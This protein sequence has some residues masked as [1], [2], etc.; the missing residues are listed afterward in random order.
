M[1]KLV[2]F[3]FSLCALPVAALAQKEYLE[4]PAD[5]I[6]I[7]IDRLIA[8]APDSLKADVAGKAFNIYSDS[9]IMGHDAVAVHIADNYFLNGLLKWSD[10]ETYPLLYTYASFNRSSL[11]GMDSPDFLM[12]NLAGGMNSLRDDAG[13]FKLLFFYDPQCA[14]CHRYASAIAEMSRNYNGG[15]LSVFAVN[16]GS[17]REDWKRYV[18]ENFSDITTWKVDFYNLWDPEDANDYHR[19]FGVLSTPALLLLDSQNRI[20][21]RQL[22]VDAAKTLLGFNNAGGKEI[23]KL[24]NDMFNALAPVDTDAIAQISKSLAAKA[25]AD[26]TMY[27]EFFYELFNYLRDSPLHAYQEG[28]ARMASRYI[29]GRPE[30]WSPEYLAKVNRAIAAYN[31]N[32]LGSKAPSLIL[33][34]SCGV[35]VDILKRRSSKYTLL[36]FHI[37][38]CSDCRREFKV[39]D[40]NESKLKIKK[41]RVVCIYAGKDSDL[42]KGFIGRHPAG[43]EYYS[44][45]N[46]TSRMGEKYDIEFVPKLYLLDR[47]GRIVAKDIDAPALMQ[48]LQ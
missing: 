17:D 7:K 5:S 6:I 40:A 42:W 35:S 44:D 43:W 13:H 28:A 41:V 12:E 36:V 39:L 2:L 1:K 22:D 32:P 15:R 20:I 8:G 9:P 47:K 27:R 30:Y 33:K 23:R 24:F 46:R 25:S 37:V 34:D 16:T 4:E 10:P 19:K 3:F 29:L 18:A 21:G 11:I 45:I 14:T 31:Q 48:Y 38:N 26:S